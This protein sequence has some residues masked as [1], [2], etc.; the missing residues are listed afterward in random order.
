M[1]RKKTSSSSDQTQTALVGTVHLLFRGLFSLTPSTR[2][3]G[4]NPSSVTLLFPEARD[5]RTIRSELGGGHKHYNDAPPFTYFGSH[6][7][8]LHPGTL[9][10]GTFTI[11]AANSRAVPLGS[12]IIFYDGDNLE[13][14]KI[15]NPRLFPTDPSRND[16]GNSVKINISHEKVGGPNVI[17]LHNIYEN[18]QD[19]DDKNLVGKPTC[20]PIDPQMEAFPADLAARVFRLRKG[21]LSGFGGVID[22]SAGALDMQRK[23]VQNCLSDSNICYFFDKHDGGRY[24]GDKDLVRRYVTDTVI[25]ERPLVNNKVTVSINGVLYPFPVDVN[26]NVFLLLQHI[27]DFPDVTLPTYDFDFALTYRT[28]NL[29]R[30]HN[31]NRRNKQRRIPKIDYCPGILSKAGEDGKV[32]NVRPLAVKP[33]ICA[34]SMYSGDD[35]A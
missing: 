28:A 31:T 5:R 4:S 26:G 18:E 14:N 35:N 9:T 6:T 8:Y 10:A 32:D 15:N 7:L 19:A 16:V 17:D 13:A 20:L 12:E 29:Q 1:S 2:L 24:R 33:I 25:F 3:A 21:E 27:G 34:M 30:I 22:G 11:D 23:R